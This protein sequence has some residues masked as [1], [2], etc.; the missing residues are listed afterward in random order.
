MRAPASS[1]GASPS[2]RPGASRDARWVRTSHSGVKLSAAGYRT[3]YLPLAL[4]KGLAP[5]TW[6][7]LTDQEYRRCRSSL[8]LPVSSSFRE[9]PFSW[10]QRVCFWAASLHYLGSAVLVLGLVLPLAIV[11]WFH[12]ED[13]Q[14]TPV[15]AVVP[16]LLSTWLVLPLLARG[17]SP[18][19]YRVE[20]I[21]AFCHL[22]AVLDALRDGVVDRFSTGA[23]SRTS[24]TRMGTPRRVALMARA[25]FVLAQLAVWGGVASY[26]VAGH[27]PGAVVPV[28]LL[29]GLQ[30]WLLLPVVVRLG[31]TPRFT[32]VLAGLTRSST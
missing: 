18:A 24:R 11:L 6:E 28:V 17:W 32:D 9:A 20:M 26:L 2:K 21:N 7:A 3:R 15:L 16:A 27:P 25:W 19:I 23:T 8:L 29:W 10:R 14:A 30:V 31:P 12:P 5:D 22:L 1:T 13:L 4:A